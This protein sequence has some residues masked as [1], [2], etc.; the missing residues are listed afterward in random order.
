MS[1]NNI[2]YN[3]KGNHVVVALI[4]K[5]VRTGS[6]LSFVQ[7]YT[8]QG[9]YVCVGTLQRRSEFFVFFWRQLQLCLHSYRKGSVADVSATIFKIRFTEI[10]VR[11][12]WTDQMFVLRTEH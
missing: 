5:M 7:S 10:S 8:V 4:V 3:K 2:Q 1:M 9:V 6:T 12:S 11:P